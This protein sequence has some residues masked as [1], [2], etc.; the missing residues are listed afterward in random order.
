MIRNF[1]VLLFL[2]LLYNPGAF[3]QTNQDVVSNTGRSFIDFQKSFKRPNDAANKKEANLKAL[4]ELKGLNW[5]AKYMYIRS[6]KYDSQLEVWV[7][8]S[9][10]EE[11]KL[12]KIYKVCALAGALGP[13]RFEGDYQVPEGFYYIDRFNPNSSYYLSLGLN[14]PN[15]SDR[16]LSDPVKPGGDIFIHGGCAT[17]GCIPILDDQI[18]ELYIL[19][20]NAKSAGLDFIPVHIFPIKYDVQKSYEYLAKITKD[21]DSLKLFTNKLE[22]AFDYFEKYHQLPLIMVKDNGEYIVSN[23][24]PR[25]ARFQPIVK[26]RPKLTPFTP[27]VRNVTGTNT[28]T[29]WPEYVGGIEAFDHF[30]KSLGKELTPYLPEGLDKLFAQVEF[31]IDADGMPVNFKII[32]GSDDYFNKE[33]LARIQKM[34]KWE[35]ALSFKTPVAKKMVQTVIVGAL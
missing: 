15:A 7:K 24:L 19:A 21:N 29:K 30:L 18:A 2:F 10:Q 4:F 27:N 32:Q 35:P 8:N 16:I 13:K 25:V 14:Y 12:L 3:S 26:A 6:F 1:L 11:Y 22:E 33:L 20:A 9:V 23:A 28:V 31:V 5:P 17:V 34:P